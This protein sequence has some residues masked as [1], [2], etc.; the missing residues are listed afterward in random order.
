MANIH[1]SSKVGFGRKVIF[2][3]T[4]SKLMGK[5]T[6][7]YPKLIDRIS[8]KLGREWS[9]DV[10]WTPLKKPIEESRVALITT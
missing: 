4:Q 10:P 7:K 6:E 9:G 3:L 1:S 2:T 5:L 8:V